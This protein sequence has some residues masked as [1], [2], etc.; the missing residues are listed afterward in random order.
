MFSSFFFEIFTRS[1][2]VQ[3]S[4]LS[5][6]SELPLSPDKRSLAAGKSFPFFSQKLRS[7]LSHVN[8]EHHSAAAGAARSS[9]TLSC[10]LC[11]SRAPTGLSWTLL[12]SLNHLLACLHRSTDKTGFTLR[13]SPGFPRGG[14]ITQGQSVIGSHPL[15]HDLLQD[16]LDFSLQVDYPAPDWILNV[17]IEYDDLT[18]TRSGR[19]CFQ[20]Y[21]DNHW[22]TTK[23]SS[24][25]KR[26]PVS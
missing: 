12:P 20:K 9:L 3:L 4:D 26:K 24:T 22:L 10:E 11:G 16:K 21:G 7:R 8:H 25:H 18:H 2:A 19:F 14:S 13:S 1:V 6:L 15:F 5:Q 17:S 23:R